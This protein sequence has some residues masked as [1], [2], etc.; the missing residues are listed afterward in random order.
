MCRHRKEFRWAPGHGLFGLCVNPSLGVR[1]S[2]RGRLKKTIFVRDLGHNYTQH[3]HEV[4][5]SPL[6]L[7]CSCYISSEFGHKPSLYK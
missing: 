1:S 2:H 5:A 4:F 7:W 3:K 6:S